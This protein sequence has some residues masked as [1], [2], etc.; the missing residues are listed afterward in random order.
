MQWSRSFEQDSPK[1][2]PSPWGLHCPL[3]VNNHL[4]SVTC[5]ER[6]LISCV[7]VPECTVH[8]RLKRVPTIV[9]MTCGNKWGMGLGIDSRA[10]E[11]VY[12]YWLEPSCVYFR[13]LFLQVLDI[14][15]GKTCT[16]HICTWIDKCNLQLICNLTCEEKL[17]RRLTH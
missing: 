3:R 17:T 9:W 5:S 8:V 1:I 11:N 10:T 6:F 2:I 14:W 7:L 4:P 16:H 13:Q 15:H 12:N